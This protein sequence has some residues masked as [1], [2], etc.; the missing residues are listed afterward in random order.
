[1]PCDSMR[2]HRIDWVDGWDGL[3][4]EMED[5]MMDRTDWVDGME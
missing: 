2:W 5:G 4:G 1:M 3:F